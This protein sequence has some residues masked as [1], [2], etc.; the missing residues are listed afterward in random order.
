MTLYDGLKNWL[1]NSR[2]YPNLNICTARQNMYAASAMMPSPGQSARTGRYRCGEFQMI[3]K[4]PK[5]PEPLGSCTNGIT[6]GLFARRNRGKP[7]PSG[8][9]SAQAGEVFDQFEHYRHC[10]GVSLGRQEA[11]RPDEH[12]RLGGD[13]LRFR[14]FQEALH[15]VTASQ[16]GSFHAAHR[17]VDRA[18]GRV[19]RLID[20]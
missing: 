1:A 15:S 20:I 18:P 5:S 7:G 6:T 11:V 8:G 14:V 17:R 12:Q 19:E 4:D 9:A 3:K 13:R 2:N 16:T 10:L